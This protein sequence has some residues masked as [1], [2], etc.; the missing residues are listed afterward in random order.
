LLD[1]QR[2]EKDAVVSKLK[3]QEKDLQKQIA[4]KKK[5]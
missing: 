3:S 2:K 5:K 1:E 4:E